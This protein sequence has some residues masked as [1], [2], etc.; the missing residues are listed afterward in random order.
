M[1]ECTI[2][3]LL[4]ETL[5]T[6][7]G[8][9]PHEETIRF[10]TASGRVFRMFHEP[11]CCESVSVNDVIGSIDD[12]IG[13]PILKAEDSTN[14]DD[15]RGIEAPDS[16]TW[17]FYHLATIKGHV[18]LRWLGESNGYYGEEVTVFEDVR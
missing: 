18:T 2:A 15:T 8:A 11:D 5:V 4:G 17:T 9:K 1:P 7:T 10:E 6:I 12:L 14:R 16:F 13:S 3:A